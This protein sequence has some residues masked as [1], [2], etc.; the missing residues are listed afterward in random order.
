MIPDSGYT[1]QNA[2]LAMNQANAFVQQ[3][4]AQAAQQL[5]QPAAAFTGGIGGA[6]PGVMS[7]AAG[8]AGAF[9]GGFGSGIAQSAGQAVG[10]LSS[11]MASAAA[12]ATP[13]ARQF[14]DIIE[15]ARY[16]GGGAPP[17]SLGGMIATGYAP[18]G[19]FPHAGMAFG[20]ERGTRREMAR[21]E[22]GR[23]WTQ[24]VRGAVHG[25]MDALTMGLSS[26]LM[27][28]TGVEAAWMGE[29]ETKRTLQNRL[30]SVRG[31]GQYAAYSGL[32][33]NRDFLTEEPGSSAMS[34]LKRRAGELQ[35]QYGYSVDQM[36]TLTR[37]ATGAID[38][39]RIAQFAAGGRKGMANLGSEIAS[40]RDT[41]ASMSR[42]MQMSE[43]EIGEFFSR[44]KSV[45]EVTGQGLKKFQQENRTLS[46][47]GP[48]SQ[49]QVA[50]M[51][52]QFT[53]MG[54]Q[55]H[56][57]GADFGTEAMG[58]ANRVAELRRS[59]VISADTLLREGGGLGQEAV[60]RMV[61]QRLQQQAGLV[62]GGNFN[63][64]LVL[65][66]QNPD[67]YSAMMGGASYMQTQG[68]VGATM[69][70]NPF[71]LLQAQLDPNAVRRVTMQA[72]AIAF[73]RSQ[74]MGSMFV[75]QNQEQIRAQMI[76]KF[77]S[78]MGF[79]VKTPQG[80]AQSRVRYEEIEIQREMLSDQLSAGFNDSLAIDKTTTASA[81]E[82]RDMSNSLV[83]IMTET[84][85]SAATMAGVMHTIHQDT[86]MKRRWS[87]AGAAGKSR[88]VREVM[89]EQHAGD[90]YAEIA[91]GG[92]GA[93]EEFRVSGTKSGIRKARNYARVLENKGATSAQINK[94]VF[95]NLSSWNL[96]NYNDLESSGLKVKRSRDGTFVTGWGGAAGAMHTFERKRLLHVGGGK[97]KLQTQ[98]MT[99]SALKIRDEIRRLGN[100]T[101]E[102]F[103]EHIQ[104]LTGKNSWQGAGGDGGVDVDEN[105]ITK[106]MAREW[107]GQLE[108]SGDR[109][110]VESIKQAGMARDE[111]NRAHRQG[112]G[113][114]DILARG[115]LEIAGNVE[116]GLADL[117]DSD[118]R[119]KE[120]FDKLSKD[121]RLSPLM[122]IIKGFSGKGVQN[123]DEF[124]KMT[125]ILGI[126]EMRSFFKEYAASE[127]GSS[128]LGGK[129]YQEFLGTDQIGNM[130]ELFK[131]MQAGEKQAF[132]TRTLTSAIEKSQ[133]LV[134]ETKRGDT[135]S[136]PL[137]VEITNLTKAAPQ[138]WLG[139]TLGL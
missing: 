44:L 132:M 110:S 45:M 40:I 19:A 82:I 85:E 61:A 105:T 54:R 63:Q 11:G 13:G 122:D 70:R 73:Q 3:V 93:A 96:E 49:K 34:I 121:K 18:L 86:D 31:A 58:Q 77:G 89:G 39:T 72:P 5:S 127:S 87:T 115:G 84:G 125:S 30:G 109:I 118:E 2:A 138:S 55:M 69:A 112:A 20:M 75:G 106:E 124:T 95:G 29:M 100:A 65:A 79:N 120:K 22:L 42:E 1:Q 37:A 9:A 107:G 8:R 97:F 6:Q 33:V 27:R 47:A 90:L 28:R 36:D 56:L 51:R 57:G 135:E 108:S 15:G 99:M 81:G 128:K 26:H 117:L 94:A 50:S 52:M 92:S 48:F 25:S 134:N 133:R 131:G 114:F 17:M 10:G 53:Q 98:T 103:L 83:G 78:Q 14:G 64:S 137:Y 67:A 130:H 59:G 113:V 139:R 12:F 7:Y 91:G 32:G 21:E 24:G 68:A 74:Q 123:K 111:W 60:A 119:Q 129:T 66:G 38:P 35:S 41:G 104:G 16:Q 102:E 23:R 76:R 4:R 46:M 101:K 71:A 80:L 116:K 62:Q 43:K 88:L 126:G 136:N